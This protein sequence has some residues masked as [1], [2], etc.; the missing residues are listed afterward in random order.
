MS[1]SNSSPTLS[2]ACPACGERLAVHAE[3]I[4]KRAKCRQCGKVFRLVGEKNPSADAP[5][6]GPN[7]DPPLAPK[8]KPQPTTVTFPCELCETRITASIA[9]VGKSTKCPDCGRRNL[10]PAPTIAAAPKVPAAMG[11]DQYGLWGVDAAPDDVSARTPMLH[12]VECGLCQTLMYATDAQVGKKLKCP[13]CGTLTLAHA[14]APVKARG[15]VIVP[16]GDEYQLDEAT[17]PIARP[18]YVPLEQRG[19]KWKREDQ[20]DAEGEDAE[21]AETRG[22]TGASGGESGE[23]PR[24]VVDPRL[25][26]D[27]YSGGRPRM[28][29]VPLVQGVW[30]ML[31]TGEVFARWLALSAV[32]TVAGWFLSWVASAMSANVFLAIPMFAAGCACFGF[33]LIIALPVMLAI[34]TESSEGNDRLHDPPNWMSFEFAQAF[35]VAIAAAVSMV[36]AGLTLKIPTVWPQ[37]GHVALA[38]A[39][40]LACFPIAQ[41]SNLEQSSAFAVFSPRLA[42]SVFRCPG[43]W[44]L[45]YLESLLLA[46]MAVAAGLAI[47][48]GPASL[49]LLLP[50]L[51]VAALLIYMRLLGRLAWWLAETMPAPD[52]RKAG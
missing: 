50:W 27:H 43:P 38:A 49:L 6:V 9:D 8:P 19:V 34:V 5:A 28:P 47:F 12:P 36:P 11:G 37:E 40:W 33:W 14:R 31:L 32:L 46:A 51:A 45:F 30:R 35:F 41:L 39:V 52:E 42:S 10:I 15:P 16:D 23:G 20:R 1:T 26:G 25:K 48:A 24:R 18:A 44:L 21:G 17:A 7:P 4:G 22:A 2:V 13:D 29:R 3:T